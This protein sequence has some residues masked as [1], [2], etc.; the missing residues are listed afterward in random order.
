MTE[1]PQDAS[2][3]VRPSP[4]VPHF[5]PLY[6]QIHALLT[7]ALQ[8]GEWHPGAVIPTEQ[9]L[10][11]RFGVSAGTVRKAI[12]QLVADHM[13]VR[14]Q[15][16]GTFVATHA[17]QRSQFRFLR[18][19][20]RDDRV[21]LFTSRVLSCRRGRA[22]QEVG[23]ALELRTGESVV[24]IRRILD[25][26]G[27]P[28][29]LDDIWLPGERFRGLN[30]ERLAAHEGPLYALFE[31]EFGTRMLQASERVRA[32]L[33]GS[34]VAGL[35]DLAVGAPLLSVER[36]SLTYEDEPVEFRRGLYNTGDYHYLNALR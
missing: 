7:R 25:F 26:E 27:R 6:R 3:G 24:Q 5:A 13:L 31:T 32:C 16:R 33:A 14:R 29:V 35:L 34:D 9:A 18:L 23:K 30:A 11:R 4:D 15:G 17:E 10:A 36:V 12:D 22:T 28:T 19:R 20:D 1:P 2:A 8:A 21:P